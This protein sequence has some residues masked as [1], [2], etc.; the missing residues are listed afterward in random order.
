MNEVLERLAERGSPVGA[1]AMI[2]RVDAELAGVLPASAPRRV[3]PWLAGALAAALVL[4]AVGGGAWLRSRSG[5]EA[6]APA[7][8][9]TVQPAWP[10]F[11]MWFEWLRPGLEPAAGVDDAVARG[12]PV[13]RF[14]FR[15]P[16][17][18]RMETLRPEG[19]LTGDLGVRSGQ[20]MHA[21]YH[22]DLGLATVPPTPQP[23]GLMPTSWLGP[24][25]PS[26]AWARA[27]PVEDSEPIAVAPS[28]PLAAYAAQSDGMRMEF[29]ADGVPVL[30]ES[31]EGA[32]FRVLRIERRPVPEAEVGAGLAAV[33]AL[34]PERRPGADGEAV[35]TVEGDGFIATL[36]VADG[37]QDVVVT[38]EGRML[39]TGGGCSAPSDPP[40]ESI[41]D[42]AAVTLPD[43]RW[44]A[45]YSG[46]PTSAFT[47]IE[48]SYPD[49]SVH[50]DDL[51]G[52]YWL[53]AVPSDGPP[54]RVRVRALDGQGRE[55]SAGE[56]VSAPGG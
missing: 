56:V 54:D 30:F 29:T 19:G 48:V 12:R 27:R 8:L 18:W 53:L 52:G 1:D 7:G 10:E 20:A 46:G 23:G 4:V 31:D 3:R 24:I 34:D 16:E 11:E 49:G 37:C 39:L 36:V 21:G 42:S 2:D 55:V 17:E 26:L 51:D 47:R 6:P 43:G 13:E 25:A 28:H 22:Y 14:L 38:A 35:R 33:Q 9:P 41:L 32:L 50:A 45:L 44:L 40:D 5:D 15:S